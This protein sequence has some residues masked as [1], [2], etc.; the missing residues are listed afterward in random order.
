[1]GVKCLECKGF[2][3]EFTEFENKQNT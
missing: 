2:E 3:S 1:M